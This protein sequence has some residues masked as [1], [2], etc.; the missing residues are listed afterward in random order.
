MEEIM[1]TYDK[2]PAG[3]GMTLSGGEPFEQAGLLAVLA[4]LVHLRGGNIITYTGYRWET[5][6]ERSRS[7]ADIQALL[8]ET[9]LL[10]DGRFVQEKRTLEAPFVGSSNQRLIALSSRGND[11]LEAIPSPPD[12]IRNERIPHAG[13]GCD[14]DHA[15]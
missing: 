11:L 5:L 13:I 6:Q 9:D 1:A 12:H 8:Q 10:I 3:T 4:E 7:E 14:T 2:N 15:V